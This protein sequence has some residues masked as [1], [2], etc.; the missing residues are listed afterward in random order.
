LASITIGQL[1]FEQRSLPIPVALFLHYAKHFL[2][3]TCC[4]ATPGHIPLPA[5]LL[6]ACLPTCLLQFP[7]FLPASGL[8]LAAFPL[9]DHLPQQTPPPYPGN[10]SPCS[11]H[12]YILGTLK[13]LTGLPCY[14][15]LGAG[16]KKQEAE[17]TY[18]P[19]STWTS[20]AKRASLVG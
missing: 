5:C 18:N 15:K 3:H 6:P 10:C 17:W 14:N 12:S 20:K 2:P 7:P 8:C 19:H 9:L 16:N 13:R 1:S 11:F 4:H